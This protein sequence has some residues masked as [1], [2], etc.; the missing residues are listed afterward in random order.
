VSTLTAEERAKQRA[1]E[2]KAAAVEIIEYVK[3]LNDLPEHIEKAVEC[4]RVTRTVTTSKRALVLKYMRDNNGTITAGELF[5]NF[6]EMGRQEAKKVFNDMIKLPRANDRV[7][8][9]Y[10]EDVKEYRIVSEGPEKP[11]GW[12]GYLPRGYKE[13]NH[14]EEAGSLT[15]Y[16]ENERDDLT[17][18]E[19]D[20]L[21]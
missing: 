2:R 11:E 3:T 15:E 6:N 4:L 18:I 14:Q 13:D 12:T 5:D 10:D 8:V 21:D 7:W 17:S 19:I 9:Y 1:K 16:D 20:D